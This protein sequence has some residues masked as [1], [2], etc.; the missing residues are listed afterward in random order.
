MARAT[1]GCACRVSRNVN[2]ATG[3]QHHVL[4]LASPTRPQPHTH[5]RAL[6]PFPTQRGVKKDQKR[7]KMAPKWRG[8]S[9]LRLA[10]IL[11]GLVAEDRSGQF[12]QHWIPFTLVAAA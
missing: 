1:I 4:S 7:G 2:H 6:S 11:V 3:C 10:T 8:N 12:P 9:A 5:A